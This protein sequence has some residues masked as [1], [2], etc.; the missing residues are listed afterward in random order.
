VL[1]GTERVGSERVI[2]ELMP[3][4]CERPPDIGI[5]HVEELTGSMREPHDPELRVEKKCGD[6]RGLEQVLKICR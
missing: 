3:E 2:H 1:Y 6:P 4:I 5:A